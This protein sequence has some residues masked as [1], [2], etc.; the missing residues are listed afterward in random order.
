MIQLYNRRRS[1]VYSDSPSILAYAFLPI[2]FVLQ[3]VNTTLILASRYG[4]TAVVKLLFEVNAN[5]SA[6]DKVSLDASKSLANTSIQVRSQAS[7][8]SRLINPAED[9]FLYQSDALGHRYFLLQQCKRP[10]FLILALSLLSVLRKP[11]ASFIR[12]FW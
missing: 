5:F 4:C 3:S 12:S 8:G 10:K 11:P 2:H 6:K 1:E 9:N 7:Y